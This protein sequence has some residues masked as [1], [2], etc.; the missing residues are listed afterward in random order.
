MGGSPVGRA[1]V[2]GMH[3]MQQPNEG[4]LG[5]WIAERAGLLVQEGRV[6]ITGRG[7]WQPRRDCPGRSGQR[8]WPRP[9]RSAGRDQLAAG[10][11]AVL[12]EVIGQLP[13]RPPPGWPEHRGVGRGRMGASGPR[14]PLAGLAV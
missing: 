10:T 11:A 2:A 4:G 3:G 13:G 5:P 14:T 12:V 9:P 1:L 6:A 8:S 7:P